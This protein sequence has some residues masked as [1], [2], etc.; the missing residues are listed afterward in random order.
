MTDC[1]FCKIAQGEIPV[2]AVHESDQV[3]AFADINPQAPQ[4]VLIIPKQHIATLNELNDSGLA[5]ELLQAV[6]LVAKKLGLAQDGYRTVINCNQH[7]GQEV[8][9]LHVHLLGGRQLNWPPG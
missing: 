9:H 6:P 7:G 2:D 1:L 5:G 4:H 8:Y 3:I